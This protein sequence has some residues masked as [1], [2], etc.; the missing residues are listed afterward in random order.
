MTPAGK[1]SVHEAFVKLNRFGLKI[2]TLRREVPPGMM[3]IGENSLFISAGKLTTVV[4]VFVGDGVN[5]TVGGCGVSEGV[6]VGVMGVFVRV[7]VF[8]C[9]PF[10]VRVG[11]WVAVGGRDVCV[12]LGTIVGVKVTVGVSVNDGVKVGVGIDPA[13]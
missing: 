6:A 9:A 7:G 8:V 13:N 12:I 11:V 1:L 5:V 4:A 2:V 3:F 10:G